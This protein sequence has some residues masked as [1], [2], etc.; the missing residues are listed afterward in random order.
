MEG[1]D[2]EADACNQA[3]AEEEQHVLVE[4]DFHQEIPRLDDWWLC[5]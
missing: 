4:Y 5:L 3:V 2:A 1:E